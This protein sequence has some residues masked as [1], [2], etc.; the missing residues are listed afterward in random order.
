MAPLGRLDTPG[1]RTRGMF[2]LAAIAV[3]AACFACIF[4]LTWALG[5]L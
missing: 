2:D 4:A 5:K 1:R 3:A